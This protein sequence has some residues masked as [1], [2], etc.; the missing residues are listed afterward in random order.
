MGCR[1]KISVAVFCVIS[2]ARERV[3]KFF[4]DTTEIYKNIF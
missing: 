2:P 4:A 1:T 3:N